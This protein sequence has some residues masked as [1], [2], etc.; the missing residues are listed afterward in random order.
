MGRGTK[1]LI[2]CW[3]PLGDIDIEMGT[4]TMLEGSNHLKKYE[5]I[6]KTYG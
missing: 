2:T 6:R 5:K 1:N 4:L 3:I